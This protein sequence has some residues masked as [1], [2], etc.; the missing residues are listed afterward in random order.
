MSA[1]M[2]KTGITSC[3]FQPD[4]G[5][6]PVALLPPPMMPSI[7][8]VVSVHQGSVSA[9]DWGLGT[10]SP[11]NCLMTGHIVATQVRISLLP[12]VTTSR[13]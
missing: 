13:K 7:L 9:L 8:M 1:Y 10:L 2:I 5:V 12:A 6:W 4:V 3:V 11:G